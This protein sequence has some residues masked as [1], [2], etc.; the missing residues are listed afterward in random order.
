MQ[1]M[2]KSLSVGPPRTVAGCEACIY[3]GHG[4][5]HK[6]GCENLPYGT[7]H[8]TEDGRYRSRQCATREEYAA[9][10]VAAGDQLIAGVVFGGD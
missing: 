10:L 7:V 2:N 1:Y 6:A 8:R 9:A 3:P 4:Y 5:A